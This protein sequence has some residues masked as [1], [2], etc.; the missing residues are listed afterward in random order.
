M[1]VALYCPKGKKQLMKIFDHETNKQKYI[2]T[3][4]KTDIG[5]ILNCKIV[6]EM[7]C[8]NV[9][10]LEMEFYPKGSKGFDC[11]QD[12]RHVYPESD[13]PDREIWDFNIIYSN[14]MD[15]PTKEAAELFKNSGKT[16]EEIGLMIGKG[17]SYT[18]YFY[19]LHL[20]NLNIFDQPLELSDYEKLYRF[21]GFEFLG[22]RW[23][24][25][26]EAPKNMIYCQDKNGNSCIMIAVE[27]E[28]LCQI[29]N[30]EVTI[31]FRKQII[32]Y[33]K[34]YA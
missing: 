13:N 14:E 10:L 26:D 19:A 32:N 12:L 22:A 34:N 30:G 31:E 25:L 29:L 24:V 33:L 2:C 3:K 5:E 28:R 27:P 11:Y 4:S 1:K 20:S 6:A 18:D 9:D 7:E 17:K 16:F 21:Q 8:D 15:V 23:C